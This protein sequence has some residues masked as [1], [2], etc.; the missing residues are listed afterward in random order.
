MAICCSA[1]AAK[2]SGLTQ[3]L[4]VIGKLIAPIGLV[5]ALVASGCALPLRSELSVD[6]NGDGSAETISLSQRPGQIVL[7]VRGPALAG[8]SQTLSFGVDPA[9]QDAVCGLP[10]VLEITE[11]DCRPEGLGDEVLEGCRAKPQS[12]DLSLSDGMCDS[13]HMYWNHDKQQLWWWR[14]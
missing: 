10:V 1:K 12:R 8:G 5:L 4:A 13:I 14:L 3:A 9:R 7:L 2:R 11:P 6:L